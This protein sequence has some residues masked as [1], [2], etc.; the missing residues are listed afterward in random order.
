MSIQGRQ[1][2]VSTIFSTYRVN[3]ENRKSR[4]YIYFK[5]QQHLMIKE[6]VED[7]NLRA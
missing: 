2:K 3:P 5:Q 4:E 7:P 6:G 1:G